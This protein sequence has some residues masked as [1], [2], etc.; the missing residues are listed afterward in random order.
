[1]YKFFD[2]FKKRKIKNLKKENEELRTGNEELRTENEELRKDK[3]SLID[4][5]S[6]RLLELKFEKHNSI[7]SKCF[8]WIVKKILPDY[9][10]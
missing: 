9:K 2:E 6:K 8:K 4:K 5:I 7:K 3:K 10:Q 1:M